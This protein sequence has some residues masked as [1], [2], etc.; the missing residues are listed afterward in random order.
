MQIKTISFLFLGACINSG[1]D[2]AGDSDWTPI[3][4]VDDGLVQR[5]GNDRV[6]GIYFS[7]A[8][9]GYVVTQG[10]GQ[11]FTD[12]G[13]VFAIAGRTASVAFSGQNG[14][15]SL[16]G[17]I[18][19]TGLEPTSNGIVAMAYSADIVT[20]DASGRFSIAKNGNL[21]GIDN[22]L[23]VRE[24]ASGTILIRDTGVVTKSTTKPGPSASYVDV[25]APTA[26]PRVPENLPPAMCQVGPPSAGVP[27]RYAA[28]I[29]HDLI[30]YTAAPD[31]EPQICISRDGGT[32][33]YPT[34][35]TVSDDAAT[36]PTGVLF[37]SPQNGLTW[38]GSQY[39]KAYVQRTTDGG[40]TWRSVELPTS[41]AAHALAL[42]AAF[43]APDGQH[44]WIVGYDYNASA[45]LGLAT[46]D[47]GATWSVLSGLGTSKLYSGFALDA[48]HVWVGGEQGVLLAGH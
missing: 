1:A 16:I 44:G 22:V 32:S 35:L 25:W 45:A 20:G 26:I 34:K 13:A 4:L 11:T 10:D 42:N 30:A 23:A 9:K 12:G 8:D 3:P 40:K 36:P 37:T 48:T 2:D 39:A 17:T 41:I 47:G 6:S 46:T 28:Y 31:N 29:G 43:F 21:E 24:S 18:D 14:G 27:T 15:P 38:W 7:S 19:F 5:P 33:F